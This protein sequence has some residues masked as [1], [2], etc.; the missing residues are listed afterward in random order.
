MRRI[1][2]L[3]FVLANF[4]V[5]AD[6][7]IASADRTLTS[8]GSEEDSRQF[9]E[10]RATAD[11]IVCGART[12]EEARSTMG[13]GGERYT[14]KRLR[15][16]RAKFPLRVIISGSGSIS[17]SAEIWSH[18]YGPIIVATTPRASERRLRWLRKHAAA[19]H[20]SRTDELDWAVFLRW[21]RREY[22]VERV[23]SEGGGEVNDGMVRAGVLRELH[24]TWCPLLIGGRSAPTLAD[25]KGMGSL[26]HAAG[27][28]L[29]ECRKVGS[30]YFL[31]FCAGRSPA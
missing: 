1:S 27:F 12:V 4:A 3:P 11:A 8:F 20:T 29:S 5:S 23:L 18:H 16:G 28:R 13:N 2:G 19:V 17:P 26:T 24:F 14:R 10:L 22:G 9:Y 7:K 15:S 30:E 6:G 31:V 25:G 21:L